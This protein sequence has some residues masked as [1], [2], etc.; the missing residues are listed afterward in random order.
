[1]LNFKRTLLP[2]VMLLMGFLT[3]CTGEL[4]AVTPEPVL[5]QPEHPSV[6]TLQ[7]TQPGA[8]GPNALALTPTAVSAPTV[9]PT[10]TPIF[11]THPTVTET[12][13]AGLTY[14]RAGFKIAMPP[15]EAFVA[16][17][18][19]SDMEGVEIEATMMAKGWRAD[20]S[21]IARDG[22]G[23]AY[24][25]IILSKDV[26]GKVMRWWGLVDEHGTAST[27]V[28]TGMPRPKSSRVKGV[29]G[30][31]VLLPEG[32]AYP[33]YFED[34]KGRRYGLATN[35]E[36]IQTL[37]ANL[38]EEDGRIQFW[39]E[40]RYAVN[41]YYGR[42]ILI[43]K[44]NLL[45]ADPEEVL[46]R[47]S[48]AKQ[49]THAS[50]GEGEDVEVGPWAVIYQPRP[51]AVIHAQVQ[52]SGEIAG[53]EGDAVVVRVEEKDGG[54]LGEAS[55]S[56]TS[57]ESGDSRFTAT[58]AFSDPPSMQNG[59]IAVYALAASSDEWMLLGWTEVILAGDVGNAEVTIV[60]PEADASVRGQVQVAGQA[61]GLEGVELLIRVEDMAG[62]VF[63]KARA[64][65]ANDGSWRARV[66]CRRPKTVRPGQIVV[67]RV[68]P[69]Q[70]GLILLARTPVTL[71]R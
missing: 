41:D 31:V 22:Y 62:V 4:P 6:Q 13:A 70:G 7:P 21:T 11:P 12:L 43:R 60:Q 24:R 57:G 34:A 40:L 39:G 37:L 59:R 32:S 20:V 5:L 9:Y 30:R 54:V 53:L 8:E 38:R 58:V 28:F 18:H 3:G 16:A 14:V 63:G 17:D 44:Y 55:A 67:Y 23:L 36:T 26:G 56:V 69:T 27:V 49:E 15:A 50:A 10:P 47:A 64:V 2:V 46:A 45:D 29:T 66:K 42:R 19:P 61:K 48:A 71:K 35:N 52:I 25:N 33:R 51:H 1:M 68:H 65:V